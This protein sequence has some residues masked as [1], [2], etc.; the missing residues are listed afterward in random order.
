LLATLTVLVS[1]SA[2]LGAATKNGAPLHRQLLSPFYSP[3]VAL[4]TLPT[5]ASETLPPEAGYRGVENF[6]AVSPLSGT[7]RYN[8]TSGGLAG[9]L[10]V[11]VSGLPSNTVV[12]VNW[13]DNSVRA[14][15]IAAF[16]TD[17]GGASVPTSVVIGRL[18]EVRGVEIVLAAEGV[19]NPSLGRLVPC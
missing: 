11:T 16:R 17:S 4:Q 18:G 1:G 7:I 2:V 14:P 8:G 10:S 19:P 15:V 6:C 9:A 13:A 12:L 3:A 5:G